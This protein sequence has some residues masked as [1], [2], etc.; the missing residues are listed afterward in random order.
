MGERR[1]DTLLDQHAKALELFGAYVRRIADDQWGAPTPCT[2]WTV[3]DLVNHVTGEQLWVPPLVTGGRT[4]EEVG[5][6][7]SG[8]VLGADPDTAWG[9]AAAAAHAAFTA[10]GAME[11]TVR[12]SYGP[13][14]AAAYCAELTADCVVHAW[15]LARGIGADDRLPDGLVE[16]SIKEVM[17][18]A[19][20]LAASGAFAPPLDVPAGA[21]AQTRLLALVGRAG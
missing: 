8:D 19:D 20:G 7:Y 5:D 3:R 18:Y 14:G 17:P 12:L 10:P 21:D 4:V 11:R 13:T 2:G 16:F 15:D 1:P 9:L 6:A